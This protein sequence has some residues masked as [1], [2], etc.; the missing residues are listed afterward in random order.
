MGLGKR[1]PVTGWGY[2]GKVVSDLVAHAGGLQAK[3]VVDV[4]L[5]PLSRK[6]G[7]SKKRLSQSLAEEGI[8]YVHLPDLGNPRDNRAG[9][10]DADGP[11]GH[12]ARMRFQT[13]VLSTA[14]AGVALQQLYE[15]ARKGP[16]VVLCYEDAERCC[17]RQLVLEA[18]NNRERE[19]ASV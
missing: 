3:T 16:V 6:P 17:H 8:D 12:A 11:S 7:F 18:L 10:A 2:E 13:E 9:F 15:Y 4:R 19:L 14:A 5:T 1:H